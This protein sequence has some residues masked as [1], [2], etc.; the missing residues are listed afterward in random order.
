[1][2]TLCTSKHEKKDNKWAKKQ[3]EGWILH[4]YIKAGEPFYELKWDYEKDDLPATIVTTTIKYLSDRTLL[5][6]ALVTVIL[7]FFSM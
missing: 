7:P 2:T 1:M 6:K 5:F 3:W 4:S